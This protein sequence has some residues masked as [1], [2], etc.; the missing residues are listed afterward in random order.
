MDGLTTAMRLWTKVLHSTA[1][2][3]R[4]AMAERQGPGSSVG[5]TLLASSTTSLQMHMPIACRSSL[6]FIGP[7]NDFDGPVIHHAPSTARRA[8]LSRTSF[9]NRI[10]YSAVSP[11]SNTNSPARYLL[12]PETSCRVHMWGPDD[13]TS[14]PRSITSRRPKL[15]TNISLALMLSGLPQLTALT[16]CT[17]ASEMLT[18]D[19][20]TNQGHNHLPGPGSP[21]GCFPHL[22]PCWWKDTPTCLGCSRLVNQILSFTKQGRNDSRAKPETRTL[23]ESFPNIQHNKASGTVVGASWESQLSGTTK[24]AAP[25]EPASLLCP[26]GGR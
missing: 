19:H 1:G 26:C 14:L 9:W 3:T 11:H 17:C 25:W 16:S 23:L 4:R 24:A 7:R 6:D 22:C 20:L 15:L 21:V 13:R 18:N 8:H 10:G 5:Q 12:R 2:A